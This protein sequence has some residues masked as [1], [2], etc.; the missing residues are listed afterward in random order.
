MKSFFK[1]MNGERIQI[2]IFQVD[3]GREDPNTIKYR[4]AGGLIMVQH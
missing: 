1:L 2:P 4:F 3:E